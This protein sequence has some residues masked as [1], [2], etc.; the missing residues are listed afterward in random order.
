VDPPHRP[1]LPHQVIE[2][3][4]GKASTVLDARTPTGRATLHHLLDGADV[5]VTG[6]RPGALRALGLDPDQ[7]EARHPGTIVVTLSAWGTGGGAWAG[8][9]GFDSLV[10]VATGIAW[11]TSPDGARPGTLPGQLLDHATGYLV[12]AG[13][14]A[15]LL[16][17]ARTGAASHVSLSLARTARW[18]LDQGTT[19]PTTGARTDPEPYRTGFGNGW[20]GTRPP[21]R[22]DGRPLSYPRLPP[23]YGKAPPA[24][25]AGVAGCSQ[26]P[27]GSQPPDD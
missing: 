1:E 4:V 5:L 27:D 12:A 25:P 3:V 17:R 23:G 8:R 26:P 9:R 13:T 14:L 2:G 20:T 21:G 11:L 7:V 6:Y 22:L 19:T 10:Q 16:W 18:L 24:W 15:A